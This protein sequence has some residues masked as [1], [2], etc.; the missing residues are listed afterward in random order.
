MKRGAEYGL[1]YGVMLCE[2]V[3]EA[4]NQKSFFSA[5]RSDRE[6]TDEEIDFL[7]ER[8]RSIL[9]QAQGP[10]LL[11]DREK[12]ILTRCAQGFTQDEIAGEIGVSRETIKKDLEHTRRV[13][14]AKNV[15]QAVSVALSRNVITLSGD[16]KG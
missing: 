11:S 3:A 1:K 2:R 10:Q 6:F 5:A 8:F 15:T 16:P 7:T 4:K 9:L 12:L 13:L 14:D